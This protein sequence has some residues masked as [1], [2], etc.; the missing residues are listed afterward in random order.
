MVTKAKKAT[1]KKTPDEVRDLTARKDPKGGSQK[2]EGPDMSE[3]TRGGPS[4]K[5]NRARL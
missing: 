1:R 5:T 3:K 2:R 4:L